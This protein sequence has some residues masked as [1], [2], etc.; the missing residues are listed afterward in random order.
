MHETLG[1]T[2]LMVFSPFSSLPTALVQPSV[3][4]SQDVTKDSPFGAMIPPTTTLP[5][6]FMA[7]AIPGAGLFNPVGVQSQQAGGDKSAPSADGVDAAELTLQG[8]Q[9]S[10]PPPHT[11][12]NTPSTDC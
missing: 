9:H 4:A 8:E 7:S 11:C 2:A 5:G 6:S 1:N 10:V 12:G 3:A